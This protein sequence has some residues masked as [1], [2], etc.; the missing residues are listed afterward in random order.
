MAHVDSPDI[1]LLILSLV[2]LGIGPLLYHL[3][4]RVGV[5]L[6]A[7]DGFVFVAIG[8]LVLLHVIPE[9]LELAGWAAV[10]GALLGLWAPSWVE[11]RLHGLARQAHMV[12]LLLALVGITLHAFVDGLALVRPHEAGGAG[13]GHV[14]PMA[15]ILHRLPVG[16]TIWFLLRPAY[17]VRAALATLTL[18]GLATTAGFF[19]GE[20]AVGDLASRGRGVFQALVAGSL[21]HVMVHRSYPIAEGGRGRT[22]GVEA[23]LGALGGLALMWALTD[24]HGAPMS[25]AVARAFLGL[26]LETAPALLVAYGAAG[27]VQAVLP[28]ASMSWMRRGGGL[29]Q[30]LRGLAF[31]LPLPICSCG[32]VPVY[33][34]LV[35]RG[36]PAA[37]GMSFLVATP[38]LSLD[39][40]LISLPLL[41]DQFTVVRVLCAA[42]VALAVGW[43]MSRWVGPLAAGAAGEGHGVPQATGCGTRRLTAGFRAALTEVVDSTAPWILLGLAIAAVA[44]PVIQSSWVQRIPDSLE[45]ALFALLGIPTYVCASGATPLAAVLIY[46]GVSPGAALAFLLT[47]PATNLSTFGVLA[48]L[49]GRRIALMF[50]GSI[51]VLA[52]LLGMLAN[53]VVP[54]GPG[55]AFV[56]EQAMELMGLKG[57]CLA[58][59]GGLFLASLLRRGPRRFVAELTSARESGQAGPAHGHQH[60]D[61]SPEEEEIGA[62]P[63]GASRNTGPHG[64]GH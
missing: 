48:S 32:V 14:L 56:G 59:V 19:L 42:A 50:G 64:H 62:E 4:R 63:G 10:A 61:P 11:H 31:G 54:V 23:G 1:H 2:V 33:R 29:S 3:A 58:F 44:A 28:Q 21:L 39:A 12:A 16:L 24:G 18:I 9:S 46:K 20:A 8:G 37:A 40:V 7:L 26:A 25:A 57:V 47:G 30:A 5:M 45:V 27:L 41:G 51:G 60:G 43:A 55:L 13:E 17:G 53:Q 15:V 34:S 38:E 36:V 6:A 35:L 22:G 49:H 52:V